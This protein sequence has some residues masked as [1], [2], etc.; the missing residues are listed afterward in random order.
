MSYKMQGVGAGSAHAIFALG[1]LIFTTLDVSA[2]ICLLGNE[3][4]PY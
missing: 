2:Q 3:G 4:I 1:T